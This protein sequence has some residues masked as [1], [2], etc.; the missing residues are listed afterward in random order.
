MPSSG[1]RSKS[2]PTLDSVVAQMLAAR[3]PAEVKEARVVAL[4]WRKKHPGDALAILSAGE[5]LE[6]VAHNRR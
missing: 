6:M 3:T 1:A 5:Q 2:A 4:A